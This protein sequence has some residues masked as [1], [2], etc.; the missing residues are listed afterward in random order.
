MLIKLRYPSP[1]RSPDHALARK[2]GRICE[3]CGGEIGDTDTVCRLR[4]VKELGKRYV[5]ETR[6]EKGADGPAG[7]KYKYGLTINQLQRHLQVS[8]G[9]KPLVHIQRKLVYGYCPSCSRKVVIDETKWEREGRREHVFCSEECFQ[10][11]RN[12]SRHTEPHLLTCQECGSTFTA[13]RSDAKTCSPA[14]RMRKSRASHK[15][16][17]IS[18]KHKPLPAPDT[19]FYIGWQRSPRMWA[20]G[21]YLPGSLWRN[22]F[23]K[24]IRDGLITRE[25]A[26]ERYLIH[27]LSSPELMAQLPELAQKVLV[28]GKIL[29]CWCAPKGG[30][31][32]DDPLHCHGQVLLRLLD[33]IR[34]HDE[35]LPAHK[36]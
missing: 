20:G 33:V 32:K 29:A 34:P 23:N 24:A 18:L 9:K 5:M 15:P 1:R 19:Y 12:A 17:V 8:D 28:E 35:T 22:P 25:E 3:G 13:K 6:C 11:H 4:F 14:C 21:Y 27:V 31:T 26:C 10:A 16:K 36:G 7:N 2:T 30:L